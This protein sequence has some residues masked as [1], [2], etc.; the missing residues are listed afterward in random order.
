MQYN[1]SIGLRSSIMN[2]LHNDSIRSSMLIKWFLFTWGMEWNGEKTD[3]CTR[4][5]QSKNQGLWRGWDNV[6]LHSLPR[7]CDVLPL[8]PYVTPF[9][10]QRVWCSPPMALCNSILYPES[11]MFSPYGL[12]WLH[13]LP[14]ECEVLPLW[15]YVTPFS[16]QSG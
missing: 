4:G 5:R 3:G 15:P 1:D 9:S 13:S 16:A 14:T 12:M 7:E 6:E 11:V 2:M 8:W 10:T